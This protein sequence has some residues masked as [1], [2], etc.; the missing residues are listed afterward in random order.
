MTLM[1][2][3]KVIVDLVEKLENKYGNETLDINTPIIGVFDLGE[4][5]GRKKLLYT[6]R[7]EFK[8]KEYNVISFIEDLESTKL[9]LENDCYNLPKELFFSDLSDYSQILRFNHIIYEINKLDSPDLIL[10]EIPGGIMPISEEIHNHYGLIAYKICSAVI[11]E[12]GFFNIFPDL[13]SRSFIYEMKNI[14]LYRLSIEDVVFC[15]YDKNIDWLNSKTE[16]KIKVMNVSKEKFKSIF[17]DLDLDDTLMIKDLK[18][19]RNVLNEIESK[20][21]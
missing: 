4:N 18:S 10:I 16:N 8:A 9:S 13:C 3:K 20:L 2:N 12:Y 6:L 5:I 15:V 1:K 14:F 21:V 17:K 11:F 7:K 19:F